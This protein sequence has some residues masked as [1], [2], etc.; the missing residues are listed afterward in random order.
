MTGSHRRLL[1]RE[2]APLENRL[3]DS[4]FLSLGHGPVPGTLGLVG[5]K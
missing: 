4:V 1:Q 5:A 3:P 2:Y